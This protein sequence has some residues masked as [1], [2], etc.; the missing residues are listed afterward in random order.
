MLNLDLTDP[1]FWIPICVI[2]DSMFAMMVC[3]FSIP[4][5]ICTRDLH[6]IFST[7]GLGSY[8]LWFEI[9]NTFFFASFWISMS[10]FLRLRSISL[11]TT[12]FQPLLRIWLFTSRILS[13]ILDF[14]SSYYVVSMMG[15]EH[16]FSSGVRVS[17]GLNKLLN[18]ICDGSFFVVAVTCAKR[19]V[20]LLIINNNP[21]V[22]ET[23]RLSYISQRISFP[24]SFFLEGKAIAAN[25]TH[26]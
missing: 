17:F 11:I 20:V 19:T 25:P 14:I 2:V 26:K 21:V 3:I 18:I 7:A 22:E 6:L 4:F 1:P 12:P 13:L 24:L 10:S 23:V 8:V 5:C 15:I 9:N 16:T